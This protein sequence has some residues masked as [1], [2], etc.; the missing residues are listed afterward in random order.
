MARLLEVQQTA[1][2]L[3]AILFLVRLLLLV[4]EVGQAR[5]PQHRQGDQAVAALALVLLAQ[6]Q[7]Q[8]ETPHLH[9]QAKVTMAAM[10]IHPALV[11]AQV[12]VAVHLPLVLLEHHLLAAQV[13][14]ERHLVLAARL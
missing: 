1:E 4:V 12:A 9:L 13:E 11:T 5:K 7:A 8:L 3:E 2:L 10:L 14:P 6:I